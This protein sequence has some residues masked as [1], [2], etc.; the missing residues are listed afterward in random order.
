MLYIRWAASRILEKWA[1]Y[2]KY[3]HLLLFVYV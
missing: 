1:V 2:S 3:Y